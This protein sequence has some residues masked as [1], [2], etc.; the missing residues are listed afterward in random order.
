MLIKIQ[1][2]IT[3]YSNDK[4]II[5]SN[6]ILKTRKMESKKYTFRRYVCAID[7]DTY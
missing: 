1:Y 2:I 7:D 4:L 3:I 5:T 6:G